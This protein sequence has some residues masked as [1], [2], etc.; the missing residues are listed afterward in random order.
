V[1]G[2]EQ[3]Q[4]WLWQNRVGV[5]F[6]LFVLGAVVGSFLN[7]VIVRLPDPQQSIIKPRSRCP[8]C[9]R[10]IR[11]FE[12]IPLLSFALLRGRCRGC[13]EPIGW[14][15]PLVE[16]LTGGLLVALF[17][18]F[19]PTLALPVHFAFSAALVAIAFIDID[20]RII[21]NEISLP[22]ILIGFGL[23][24]LGREGFWVDSLIGIAAGGGSLLLLSLV[25]ALIRGREGMGMGDVKLLAML[26]AWLGWRS[27]LFIV[28]FASLQGVLVTV[29]MAL[30]GVKLKPPLPEEWEL[31]E[32]AAAGPDPAASGEASADSSAEASGLAKAEA[33][34]Q[35]E[36][37]GFFGAAIPFGPFMALAAVEYLFLGQWFFDLIAGR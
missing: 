3:V 34:E 2:V 17:W 12:N 11:W 7:V 26:G 25:Y 13:A 15:Y 20:H 37:V 6:G 35:E 22:G 33:V 9:G 30:A 4:Y 24:F 18:Q 8:R 28:L 21:P 36:D 16:A 10:P 19:G 23:S 29:G 14:R 27:L 32:Q 1:D 31:E 5:S